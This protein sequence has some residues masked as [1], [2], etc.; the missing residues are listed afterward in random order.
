MAEE[1]GKTPL[2]L[3]LGYL[4]M[5]QYPYNFVLMLLAF[6]Y[7]CLGKNFELLL[8]FLLQYVLLPKPDLYKLHL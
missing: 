8:L 2:L 4:S 5:H 1:I 3:I 6:L 7:L